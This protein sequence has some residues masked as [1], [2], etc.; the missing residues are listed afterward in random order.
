ME[1]FLKY[2]RF[3]LD[4]ADKASRKDYL[5]EDD[6]A[7]INGELARMKERL[8]EKDFPEIAKL[9]PIQVEASQHPVSEAL[10]WIIYWKSKLMTQVFGARDDRAHAAR[11]D[12]IRDFRNRVS[13]VLFVYQGA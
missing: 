8:S 7:A 9:E 1:L 4:M 3:L 5:E 12:G 6:I 11:L 10:E 2:L 13:H